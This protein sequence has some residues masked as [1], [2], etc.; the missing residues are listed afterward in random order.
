MDQAMLELLG[1]GIL[2]TLYMTLLSTFLAYVIGLPLGVILVVTHQDG[3]RPLKFIHS[4]LGILVNLFRSIPFIIL[5]ILMMPVTRLIIG[6]TIGSSAVVV[7]LVAAAA[8]YVARVV[9]SSLKEV[10]SGVIEA[11]QSMGATNFQIITKVLLPEAKP[12][13]LVGAAIAVTTI[14]GYSTMAGFVGGGGLGDLAVR[15]GYYRYETD[16]ML[17]AVA[18]LVVIVQILQEIGMKLSQK[19]DKRIG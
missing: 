8:P 16:V 1:K 6:T 18:L 3:I 15:Y 10:N 12:S 7:P 19:S 14:L 17:I 5:L 9:E 13:L 2:E 11:A 4:I